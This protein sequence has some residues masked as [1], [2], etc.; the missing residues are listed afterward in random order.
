MTKQEHAKLCKKYQ[1]M[2][3]L[4]NVKLAQ[5]RKDFLIKRAL[6]LARTAKQ[7]KNIEAY[8]KRKLNYKPG[9]RWC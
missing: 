8:R 9:K 5:I 6:T 2:D 7:R 4:V 3:D 1:A